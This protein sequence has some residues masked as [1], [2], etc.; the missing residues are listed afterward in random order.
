MTSD[1][2]LVYPY[3]RIAYELKQLTRN[4]ILT[5]GYTNGEAD[6]I[7][8]ILLYAQLRGNNQGVVK[9]IGKGIPKRE[10]AVAPKIVKETPISALFDGNETHA[11]VVMDQVADVAIKKAKKS[12]I[13]M[14]GNFNTTESTGALGYYV[15]KVAKEGLIGIAYASAPFQTT[16]P[17]GS[18]E[19]RFCTNPV[20]YG[21]PT[22]NDSIILDMTT[23]AIAYYGLI[24][25][26]T[27]NK[28][29]P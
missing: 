18:T 19:A 28:T 20:A 23:S 29:V 21:I 26:K 22:E 16:A 2:P 14:V 13:G 7:Q 4:A 3:V 25:A 1:S 5:Y 24:E 8:E 17:Y 9:L 11:M 6:V 10:K 15:N 27:A 12:G